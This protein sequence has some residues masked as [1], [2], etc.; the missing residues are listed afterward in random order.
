VGDYGAYPIA[1]RFK[2]LSPDMIEKLSVNRPF[3][4]DIYLYDDE[5]TPTDGKKKL[6]AYL[7]K[8]TILMKMEVY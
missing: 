4:G 7:E 1:F 8:L 2:D 6:T 3:N 5:S